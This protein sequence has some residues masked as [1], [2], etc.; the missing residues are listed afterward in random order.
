MNETAPKDALEAFAETIAQPAESNLPVVTQGVHDLQHGAVAVPVY[1]DEARV[2]R[3]I[4]ALAAAAGEAWFYRF[5]VKS[6]KSGRTDFVEGPSIKLAN[7]IARIYGN[8]EVDIRV[9]D[10]GAHWLFLARF[11]DLETGFAM[12]RPFQQRKSGGSM[13]DDQERRLDQS[14]QIGTSKA[15]RNVITNAL[16]TYADF[17][18]QEARGALVGKIGANLEGYRKSTVAR[19]EQRGVEV[20]R[21][22][23]VIGRAARDWLATDVAKV[24][25]MM[26]AVA[27][28]MAA[29]DETFPPLE[30][31]R[32]APQADMDNYAGTAE[33][34]D[35]AASKEAGP[36]DAS[37]E[38][39]PPQ[40]AAPASPAY[41]EAIDKLLKLA[42]DTKLDWHDRV[43]S[44]EDVRESWKD[45]LGDDTFAHQLFR[46]ALQVATGEMTLKDAKRF[47]EGWLP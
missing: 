39:G 14:F 23:A 46:T 47:L 32:K 36:E 15:I 2:L 31:A 42:S 19:I 18:M 8:C 27:D 12:T 5:P 20:A 11:I 9:Q 35:A 22:E 7:D 43:A 25:S 3:R 38:A 29:V 37:K 34:E 28:G 26:T 16:Q 24:I 40:D 4:R 44:I 6:R 10:L 30:T 45:S 41:R 1:R 13:G 21:V 17:G 33:P